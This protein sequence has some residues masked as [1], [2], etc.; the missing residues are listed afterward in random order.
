MAK[1]SRIELNKLNKNY[2]DKEIKFSIKTIIGRKNQTLNLS[3]SIKSIEF[4]KL[5]FFIINLQ[6][7]EY[8]LKVSYKETFYFEKYDKMG[9]FVIEGEELKELVSQLRKI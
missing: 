5:G 2:L 9:K 4:N 8:Y 7:E 6:K 1:N 3:E